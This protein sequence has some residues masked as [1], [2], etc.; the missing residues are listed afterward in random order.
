MKDGPEKQ[1]LLES[2]SES[3]S[4]TPKTPRPTP[5]ALVTVFYILFNVVSATGIVFAN[6]VVLSPANYGWSYVYALTFLHTSTS[7]AGMGLFAAL[8]M[9]KKKELPKMEVL[10]LSMAYV[11]YVVLNN[12][13]LKINQV[14][15]YQLT[16]I[17]IAPV[18]LILEVVLLGKR[19][20]AKVTAS[21]VMVC[22]GV[23][24]ATV[25][26]KSILSSIPGLA[27]GFAAVL[28]T[29]MYQIW[30]G[31]YQ[32]KLEASSMQLLDQYCPM[33]AGMLAFITLLA[34]PWGFGSAAPGTIMGYEY[35]LGSS[36]CILLSC[37]LGLAV[38]LS[39]FLVIGATSSLTYNI[40]GHIKTVLIL[41]GGYMFFGDTMTLEKLGGVSV[42]M[43]GIV[44]YSHLQMV[45]AK[46]RAAAAAQFVVK[47]EA[48]K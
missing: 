9:Y 10:P 43:C 37:V 26:D 41:S 46:E 16:K 4:S 19:V 14:G 1:R 31:S 30:A 24:L 3:A 35:T 28:V 40:V 15:F 32:K 12:L 5:T 47:A 23:A 45:A 25:T 42:A 11:G 21:V 2:D 17:C 7:W 20:T 33:A 48:S 29:A 36:F 44:W 22:M 27:V 38:N 34:D 39:T 13:S 6:K 18:V 8:K